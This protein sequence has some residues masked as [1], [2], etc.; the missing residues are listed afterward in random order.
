MVNFTN[1][2]SYHQ[3]KY[4]ST[5]GIRGWVGPGAG[6]DISKKKKIP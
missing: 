3:E 4:L 5:H 6:T 1:Q 2:L